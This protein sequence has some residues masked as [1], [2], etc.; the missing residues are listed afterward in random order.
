MDG[1]CVSCLIAPW[2]HLSR[3]EDFTK[4]KE[5]DLFPEKLWQIVTMSPEQH[6]ISA[7]D[8]VFGNLGFSMRHSMAF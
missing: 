3:M 6:V 4:T 1:Q 7:L 8:D 5:H 2:S